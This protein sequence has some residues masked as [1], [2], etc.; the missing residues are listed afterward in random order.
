MPRSIEHQIDGLF[1]LAPEEFVAA[2][3]ALASSLRKDDPEGSARVRHLRRPS[4][5]AW[6]INRLVRTSRP[7][8][9]RLVEAGEELRRAQ[10]LMGEGSSAAEFREAV[11]A[12][13]DL[14]R[15]LTEAARRLLEEGGRA[16]GP[17]LDPIT[18]TLEAASAD[19]AAAAEVLSGR[20][21]RE[22]TPPSGL[23]AQEI[24]PPVS[25]KDAAAARGAGGRSRPGSASVARRPARDQRSQE[26]A[27]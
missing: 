27:R 6:A 11:K 1:E 17:H 16:A 5:S 21:E 15:Q 9:H 24:V 20:L 4:A 19:P 25:L 10:G 22:L 26:R 14:V 23:G 18:A 7:D 3:N 8:V 12:R 2:R 13:R